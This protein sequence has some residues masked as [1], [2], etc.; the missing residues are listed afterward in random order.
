MPATV[1]ACS[2]YEDGKSV[3]ASPLFQQ[4]QAARDGRFVVFDLT[5]SMA[6][7]YGSGLSIPAAR[8]ALTKA[9]NAYA[10]AA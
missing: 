9:L 5:E 10:A 8:D 6:T 7:C 2:N 4:L 1:K 3:A